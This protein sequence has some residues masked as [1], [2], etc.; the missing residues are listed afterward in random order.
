M[1]FYFKNPKK[2]EQAPPEESQPQVPQRA[3][4]AAKRKEKEEAA[5]KKKEIAVQK[6]AESETSRG[7]YVDWMKKK[8]GG[9]AEAIANAAAGTAAR[10]VGIGSG[11]AKKQEA[12]K[13][14]RLLAGPPPPSV[15]PRLTLGRIL[16]KGGVEQSVKLI[17]HDKALREITFV[18]LE[19]YETLQ[20]LILS[21]T[22]EWPLPARK[23]MAAGVLAASGDARA[24]ARA[25]QALGKLVPGVT[26]QYPIELYK[27]GGSM[28]DAAKAFVAI[29]TN[30]LC[31][32]AALLPALHASVVDPKE[33]KRARE[34]ATEWLAY[35]SFLRKELKANT[36]DDAAPDACLKLRIAHLEVGLR[37]AFEDQGWGE[38]ALKGMK[39]V[40]KT[41]SAVFRGD[42]FSALEGG[43][44]IMGFALDGMKQ[45][46]ARQL[47]DPFEAINTLSA[48]LMHDV[49]S[50]ARDG[51][52]GSMEGYAEALAAVQARVFPPDE[53]PKGGGGGVIKA[54]S[55]GF[56]ALMK[57]ANPLRWEL[58]GAFIA[59]VGEAA[60]VRAALGD[61]Q[62]VTQLC[63]PLHSGWSMR[64]LLR[65][66]LPP[67][68]QDEADDVMALGESPFRKAVAWGGQLPN[69]MDPTKDYSLRRWLEEGFEMYKAEA[70]AKLGEMADDIGRECLRQ[71]GQ[72]AAFT[73]I[74]ETRR[75]CR[76]VVM[77]AALE[78]DGDGGCLHRAIEQRCNPFF[79]PERLEFT[80]VSKASTAVTDALDEGTAQVEERAAAVKQSM[81]DV[82]SEVMQAGQKAHATVH[83][84]V[85]CMLSVCDKALEMEKVCTDL[86]VPFGEVETPLLPM[87]TAHL[88][89]AAEVRAAVGVIVGHAE[90]CQS[91]LDSLCGVVE[92]QIEAAKVTV[93]DAA[94][95][96]AEAAQA[97]AATLFDDAQSALWDKL[98]VREKL[99][100]ALRVASAVDS[101]L[102]SMQQVTAKLSSVSELREAAPELLLSGASDLLRSHPGPS[103]DAT[104]QGVLLGT[105]LGRGRLGGA[106]KTVEELHPEIALARPNSARFAEVLLDASNPVPLL[107]KVGVSEAELCG[108]MRSP[109][110]SW[111]TD[112]KRG[113]MIASLSDLAATFTDRHR[114]LWTTCLALD[115][116]GAL[117]IARQAELVGSRDNPHEGLLSTL[118]VA[119]ANNNDGAAA[120]LV[121]LTE[122]FQSRPALSLLPLLEQLITSV[123]AM[124]RSLLTVQ[125]TAGDVDVLWA[126]S[127]LAAETHVQKDDGKERV[128][129]ELREPLMY[130]AARQLYDLASALLGRVEDTIL[131]HVHQ[132]FC[133]IPRPP[134]ERLSTHPFAFKGTDS[135]SSF[136]LDDH[137]F[138]LRNPATDRTFEPTRETVRLLHDSLQSESNLETERIR[139]ELTPFVS[140]C[141]AIT[142]ER[143]LKSDLKFESGGGRLQDCTALA[144]SAWTKCCERFEAVVKLS[145]PNADAAKAAAAADVPI[146]DLWW[147]LGCGLSD[148]CHACPPTTFMEQLSSA[149]LVVSSGEGSGKVG[150]LQQKV[151]TQLLEIR[152]SCDAVLTFDLSTVLEGVSE[153]MC[154]NLPGPLRDIFESTS[155]G[156]LSG[157]MK[158]MDQVDTTSQRT[159]PISCISHLTSPPSEAP[160]PLL[161]STGLRLSRLAT[162]ACRYTR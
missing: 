32:A 131:E 43:M 127:Y 159:S 55:R 160:S 7:G 135:V 50:G 150:E 61:E 145:H 3:M 111:P 72:L 136:R 44:D 4:A 49:G 59:M 31:A 138:V 58:K 24:R 103:S 70:I 155:K 54:M 52:R 134:G 75:A 35:L 53:E 77:Y 147:R 94:S 88:Q 101:L 149:G 21:T 71:L 36:G 8:A 161:H 11:E 10:V 81:N 17:A 2:V 133:V 30:A 46:L 139:K 66:G 130:D 114:H 48:C 37:C 102:L 38:T 62:A 148:D 16:S 22:A 1:R 60:V 128:R 9:A 14:R 105:E 5:A 142:R 63:F 146:D 90:E 34:T 151:V 41:A 23:M 27:D 106:S 126:S 47:Y 109:A 153:G 64:E 87:A 82:I 119:R 141:E 25:T 117:L 157:M 74:A 29:H 78:I 137:T 85:G 110:P 108:T 96:V 79:R 132:M 20:Q 19:H 13:K 89:F 152:A 140:L 39:A 95:G 15:P 121:A 104:L 97:Q 100:K 91:S 26:Q 12:P 45:H 99:E 154:T 28:R 144:L 156:L 123:R 40:N 112:A 143:K 84:I 115:K 56:S 86:V 6:K 57:A 124:C 73:P 80:S 118:E 113:L 18:K 162:P 116:C 93:S 120:A 83:S 158:Q 92:A 51:A 42:V 65:Y 69:V 129:R 67:I 76:R 107:L 98:G 122:A 125:H 68:G 33:R